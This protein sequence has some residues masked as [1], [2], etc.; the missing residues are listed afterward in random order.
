[1]I[2]TCPSC[3][4]KYRVRDEVVPKQGAELKCAKCEAAFAAFPPEHSEEDIREALERVGQMMALLEKS[5]EGY[6]DE[7]SRFK[8]ENEHRVTLWQQELRASQEKSLHL[9]KAHE[10][11]END[12]QR[13]RGELTAQKVLVERLQNQSQSRAEQTETTGELAEMHAELESLRAQVRDAGAHAGVSP[14][15][16]SLLA[17][18][19]PMLW[20]LDSAITDLKK[21]TKTQPELDGHVRHL[22]LL[23]GILKRLSQSA[24]GGPGA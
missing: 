22:Q 24:A 10:K 11:L 1:M 9:R 14:E 19:A 5:R 21:N 4:A 23:S 13:L 17:A 12:A 3:D 16:V 6:R 15:L 2:V 20:G 7:L 8:Q 18:I